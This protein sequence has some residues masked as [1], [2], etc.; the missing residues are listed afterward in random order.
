MILII[1]NYDSFTYNLYQYLGELGVTSQV[2][3]NNE[4]SVDEVE[5]LAPK[6]ILISPG[7]RT[8]KEAG[9]APKLIKKLGTKI[10]ILG[11]CLGHQCIG[12]AYGGVIRPAGEI[13][14]GKLSDIHHDKKGIFKGIPLPFKAIRYHSLIVDTMNL[15]DCLTITAW[16]TKGLIMGLKHKTLDIQGIQFHPESIM[17]QEGK[18]ILKNW[19]DS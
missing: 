12:Y 8:P 2:R 17:T 3:R 11:I 1:D 10:P 9:I 19:I 4:I 7:P 6:K 15:P 13:M 18:K 5:E 14:H 16:T